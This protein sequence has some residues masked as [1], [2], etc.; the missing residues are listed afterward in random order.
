MTPERA[1][2]FLEIR[3]KRPGIQVYLLP[4]LAQMPRDYLTSRKDLLLQIFSDTAVRREFRGAALELLG[5]A[6]QQLDPNTVLEFYQG[7]ENE[8][9]QAAVLHYIQDTAMPLS[10]EQKMKLRTTAKGINI[11]LFLD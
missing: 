1:D 9:V 11:Q 3:M 10:M 5:K 7:A 2:F 8:R 6:G 4:S